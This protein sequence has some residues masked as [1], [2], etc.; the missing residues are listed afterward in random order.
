MSHNNDNPYL[1]SSIVY[2]RPTKPTPS[3]VRGAAFAAAWAITGFTIT[4]VLV[5]YQYGIDDPASFL[6]EA[7]VQLLFPGLA[8]GAVFGLAAL[9]NYGSAC[10]IGFI[11]ALM[12]IGSAALV[13][14][15]VMHI[16]TFVFS[17]YQQS[18][19]EDPWVYVRMAIL[20]AFPISYATVQLRAQWRQDSIGN[21]NL[22]ETKLAKQ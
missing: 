17:L 11:T 14:V 22:A 5:A 8:C 2:A 3:F 4:T 13:G 10:R 19:T 18:Y 9:L 7:R 12:R 16:A 6:Q 21:V 1:S 15:L 20:L